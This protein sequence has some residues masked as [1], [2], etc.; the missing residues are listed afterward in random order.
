MSRL[1]CL[2]LV[3]VAATS[4]VLVS[5]GAGA[6]AAVVDAAPVWPIPSDA[7][8]APPPIPTL[9]AAGAS[10][11]AGEIADPVTPAAT[12]GD[13]YVQGSYGDRWTANSTW[14]EYRCAYEHVEDYPHPCAGTG[15]CDAVCYGYPLDCFTI[16][17]QRSDHFYWDGSRSIFYGESYSYTVDDWNGWSSYSLWWWDGPTARWYVVPPPAPPSFP[18]TASFTFSCT[19]LNCSFDGGGSTAAAGAIASYRWAFGD[20]TVGSGINTTHTYPH[21]GSYAASLTVADAAGA[22]AGLARDVVVANLAPTA[23][24]T[25]SCA[26]LRCTVDAGA[27]TDRDGTVAGYGWTFGDG[28]AGIGRT[29]VH[30]Y[31][32]AGTYTVTLSITDNDGGRASVS[33]RINPISLSARGY[34]LNGQQRVDLSWNGV[35][36]TSFDAYRDGR[37]IAVVQATTYTDVVAKGSHIYRVCATPDAM[38]SSDVTVTP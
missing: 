30:D 25:V 12:C 28:T 4:V 14:W 17:E 8:A 29:T 10:P 5:A 1:S 18:P 36:G 16:A 7:P 34:K 38:C 26:G 11:P 22:S 32:R 23:A 21:A 37:K 35:A 13:W 20:G 3:M 31:P 27:S 2:I 33:H 24:F 6:R 15:A 19:G 9:P